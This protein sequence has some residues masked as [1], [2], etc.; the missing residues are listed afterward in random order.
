[1]DPATALTV[2]IKLSARP[3]GSEI[4]FAATDLLPKGTFAERCPEMLVA[5]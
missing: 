5:R 4:L 2:R 1:M 3:S